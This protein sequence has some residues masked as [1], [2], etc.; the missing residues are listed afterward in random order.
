M[1]GTI[2]MSE[3]RQNPP[4]TKPHIVFATKVFREGGGHDFAADRR[5]CR[6]VGFAGLAPRGGDIY[7]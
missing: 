3:N 6:E 7:M 2:G 5:G 4:N 1:N